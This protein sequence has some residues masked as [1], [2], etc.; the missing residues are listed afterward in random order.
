MMNRIEPS[1]HL[2]TISGSKRG[3]CNAWLEHHRL[4]PDCSLEAANSSYIHKT[5]LLL[6]EPEA[7]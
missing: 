6:T 3:K 5:D 1:D 2:P 7:G 4:H